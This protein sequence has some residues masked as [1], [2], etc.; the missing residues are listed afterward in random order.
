[1]NDLGTVAPTSPRFAGL[2][3][4][5]GKQSSTYLS[6]RVQRFDQRAPDVGAHREALEVPGDVLAEVAAPVPFTVLDREEG[7]VP[8][9]DRGHL[10]HRGQRALRRPRERRRFRKRA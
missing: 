3:S 4:Q 5:R 6:E 2:N 9:H 10:G 1:M 8:V 7:G